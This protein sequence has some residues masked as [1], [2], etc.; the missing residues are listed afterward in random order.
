MVDEIDNKKET[1]NRLDF[2]IDSSLN[3]ETD[4]ELVVTEEHKISKTITTSEDQKD[5]YDIDSIEV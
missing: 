4:Y 5:F 3:W 2:E 1:D